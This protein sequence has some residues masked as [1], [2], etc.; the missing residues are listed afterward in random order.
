MNRL[1][2]QKHTRSPNII[3]YRGRSLSNI[4]YISREILSNHVN[5][6]MDADISIANGSTL[7][8]DGTNSLSIKN[9]LAN[10]SQIF[11]RYSTSCE[12]TVFINSNPSNY[13][14]FI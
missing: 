13:N 8:N 9:L 1:T 11:I 2:N 4:K 3:N 12:S 14:M 6:D 7:V 10:S 5:D